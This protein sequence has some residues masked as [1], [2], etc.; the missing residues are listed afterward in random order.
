MYTGNSFIN[1]SK[2]RAVIKGPYGKELK[3]DLYG[4]V[5]LFATGIGIASQLPYVKKPLKGYRNC[6]VKTRR[7]ALFWEVES[8]YKRNPDCAT[9][10]LIGNSINCLGC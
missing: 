10:Q 5:L 2:I 6:E 8:K 7:I 3:L 1:S 4:T 9:K